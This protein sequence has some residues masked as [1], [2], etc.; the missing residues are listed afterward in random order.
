MNRPIFS[1][2]IPTY[3]NKNLLEVALSSVLRQREVSVEIIVT[4][5]STT[6]DI[7]LYISSLGKENI[8]YIHNKPSL[9]AVKNWNEGLKCALGQYIIVLHH[10][11][12]FTNEWYLK[13]IL[14]QMSKGYDIVV[15]NVEVIIN[16]KEHRKKII[17]KLEPYFLRYPVSL[18]V[19][20]AIGPCACL[21]VRRDIVEKF[22]E[23][24]CWYVD[25]EWYYRLLS[26]SSSIFFYNRKGIHSIH[27]HQGQITMNMNFK[28]AESSDYVIIKKKYNNRLINCSLSI[29]KQFFSPIYKKIFS[30]ILK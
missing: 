2:I 29:N 27:G 20:N 6:D 22:D 30:C 19:L 12:S 17:Q 3:N 1:V 14:S 28:K 4:D 5:D 25:V 7:E 18:F 21:T 8:R 10:D 13:D 26:K 16:G 11:E 9:G 24:L 15:S 23:S